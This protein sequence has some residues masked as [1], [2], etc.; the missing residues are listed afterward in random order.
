MRQRVFVVGGSGGVGRAALKQI[1]ENDVPP[2][3]HRNPTELVGIANSRRV[4]F[5]PNGIDPAVL[6]RAAATKAEIETLL[7]SGERYGALEE[8]LEMVMFSG[9]DGEIIFVDATGA[10]EPAL[11]F[12]RAVLGSPN[13]LV[14]ANKNP[15]GLFTM[16]DFLELTGSRK[17]DFNPTVMAGAGAITFGMNR[18]DIRDPILEI[19]GMLSGT[20]GYIFSELEKGGTSFSE[21][22][23][24]AQEKGFT[25]PNPYDDLNGLDVARKLLILCRSAGYHVEFCQVEIEPLIGEHFRGLE[26]EAFWEALAQE[27]GRFSELLSKAERKNE[28]LRFSAKMEL[29]GEEPALSVKLRSYAKDSPFA[30]LNGTQNLVNFRTKIIPSHTIQSPGAGLEITAASIRAGI[31]NMLP[32]TFRR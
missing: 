24:S 19:E 13:H 7:E 4:L 10:T 6:S 3:G 15:V 20:A 5:S 1:S 16:A 2:N 18:F 9:L 12:H 25:E 32:H 28:V 17:Y 31:A 29:K 11:A 23:R 26:G 8:L 21:V 14:T 27:N 30:H 22:V